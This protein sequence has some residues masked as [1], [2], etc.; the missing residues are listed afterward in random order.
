MWDE[1]CI[2]KPCMEWDGVQV[3]TSPRCPQGWSRPPARHT[4]HPACPHGARM[5]QGRAH[6]SKG[7]GEPRALAAAA[8]IWLW[9]CSAVGGQG[10]LEPDPGVLLTSQLGGTWGMEG[11]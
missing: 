11:G 2:V 9:L 7:L 3:A 4:A 6:N 8:H 5:A 10:G 1:G